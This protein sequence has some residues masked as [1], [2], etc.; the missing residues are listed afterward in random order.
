[1]IRNPTVVII[2]GT[3]TP[4]RV[5]LVY[6]IVI[7]RLISAREKANF[8]ASRGGEGSCGAV[9][10][11]PRVKAVSS[12]LFIHPGLK[13]K[14]F[15]RG[16]FFLF[17]TS[18]KTTGVFRTCWGVFG[19]FH[20]LLDWQRPVKEKMVRRWFIKRIVLIDVLITV[21]ISAKEIIERWRWKKGA[22][23]RF[24]SRAGILE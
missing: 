18:Y 12:I 5:F 23:I 20:I 6:D 1:M 19:T 2:L 17:Y 11:I 4:C 16:R 15:S 13:K 8:S 3:G 14:I 9:W 10:L 21:L 7:I 22:L 24:R